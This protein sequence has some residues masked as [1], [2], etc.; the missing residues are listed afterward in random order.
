MATIRNTRDKILQAQVPRNLNPSADKILLMTTDTPVFNVSNT[1][2]GSPA[3]ITFTAKPLNI[4]VAATLTVTSGTATL[5]GSGNVRTLAY[6]NMTTDSVTV[7][8][9]VTF[10]GVT[11]T[12]ISIV[13][14]VRQGQDGATGTPGTSGTA[15]RVAYTLVNSSSLNSTPTSANV[16]GDSLP[17]T[18]TWGETNAW[19][20]TSPT[21]YAAGQSVWLSN[22]L[23]NPTTNIT[24]WNVPYLANLKVG[25][26]S[27]I[28]PN[29]GSITQGALNIN[30][31]FI[32]N[33]DGTT[34]IQSNTTGARTVTNNAGMKVY[35]G[36][37]SLPRVEVGQLS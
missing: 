35:D 31:L 27:I 19:Q 21:S 28:T 15:A 9:T 2:V 5:G 30:G 32:V 7:T 26:L 23:Y 8:A 18:G 17:A 10:Q 33:A 22:G 3:V 36:I 24:T 20:A 29:L 34:T 4:P 13:S 1:G 14:K 6:T 25:S 12:A 11:Y 16:S 37:Q